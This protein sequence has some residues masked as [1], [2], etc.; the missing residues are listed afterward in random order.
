MVFG[1]VH[2]SRTR[3]TE[4]QRTNAHKSS[5]EKIIVQ[6]CDRSSFFSVIIAF[7]CICWSPVWA[8]VIDAISTGPP[9]KHVRFR[10]ITDPTS[11]HPGSSK[12]GSGHQEP[13]PRVLLTSLVPPP[14][15]VAL[16]ALFLH[17]GFRVFHTQCSA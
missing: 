6:S 2:L 7:C 17:W 16:R 1:S 8:S 13:H 10:S 3:K 9:R 5:P 12:G 4:W 15:L 14:A 11:C